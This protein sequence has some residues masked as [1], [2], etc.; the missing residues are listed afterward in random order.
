MNNSALKYK[1]PLFIACIFSFTAFA[2]ISPG[3]LKQ[4][5]SDNRYISTT[6]IKAFYTRMNYKTAWIQQENESNRNILF[7]SLKL[8][9]GIGL[10]KS[11]YRFNY[12]E[13]VCNNTT[14]LQNKNDSLEAEFRITDAAIQFYN[15]V[16]YGNSKPALG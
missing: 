8:S 15:D 16:A 2:Q 13:S 7:Y 3:E 5:I 10:L 4:F 11:D 1:L 14:A 9:S 12:I 6:E